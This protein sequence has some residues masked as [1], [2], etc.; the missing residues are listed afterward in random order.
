MFS[1]ALV[2][3]PESIAYITCI[4]QVTLKFINYTLVNNG[5]F[6][7]MHFYLVLNLITDKNQSFVASK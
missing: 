3:V 5:H 4:T 7:L 1:H 2:Q 6:F